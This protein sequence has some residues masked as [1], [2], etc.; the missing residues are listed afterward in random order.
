MIWIYLSYMHPPS[1]LHPSTTKLASPVHRPRPLGRLPS[2]SSPQECWI[3]EWCEPAGADGFAFVVQNE[4]RKIVG[5]S[6]GLD[7]RGGRGST[8]KG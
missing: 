6:G 7:H 5:R 3:G 4:G 1:I 2:P 8:L